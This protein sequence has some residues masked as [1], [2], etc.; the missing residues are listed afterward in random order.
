MDEIVPGLRRY[1]KIFREAAEQSLGEADTVLRLTKFFEEVLGYDP[2]TEITR[3]HAIKG[4]FVDIALKV[5]D[6]VRI[7]VEAKAAGTQLRDSHTQQ[8]QNYAA[9]RG[10][11]WV[12][13]TNGIRWV[14]YKVE[15]GTAIEA[16]KVFDVDLVAGPM[17]EVAY[18]LGLIHRRSMRRGTELERYYQRQ[19]A[20]SPAVVVRALASESVITALRREIRALAGLRVSE[21]DAFEALKSIINPTV[22]GDVSSLTIRRKPT[23][24][25]EGDHEA[26]AAASGGQ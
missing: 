22:L 20:L 5:E 2:F 25:P 15:L 19:R 13:L 17:D 14:L 10:I 11:P 9:N 4:T 6:Q 12:L 21:D 1:S 18:C 16:T 26:E 8:A 24:I 3:E 7:L 23:P